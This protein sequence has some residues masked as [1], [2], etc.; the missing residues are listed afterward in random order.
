MTRDRRLPRPRRHGPLF[1]LGLAVLIVGT[2]GAGWAWAAWSTPTRLTAAA[3]AADFFPPQ[4]VRVPQIA[5]T[6]AD[7]EVLTVVPAQWTGL[8][9]GPT[10]SYTWTR[11]T[12]AAASS[13]SVVA[14]GQ[15]ATSVSVPTGAT[16]TWRYTVTETITNGTHTA[17][18]SS[19]PTPSQ[20]PLDIVGL[21]LIVLNLTIRLMQVTTTMPTVGGTAAVGSTLTA[22][23]GA[24]TTRNLVGALT[25]LLNLDAQQISYQWFRCGLVGN[26]A[27]PSASAA[28]A[29]E[30]IGGA[31]SQTYVPVALDRG[32]RLQVRVRSERSLLFLG[33]AGVIAA[34]VL[35]TFRGAVYAEPTAVVP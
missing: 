12:L 30:E 8:A 32:H 14:S 10:R 33:V 4:L 3:T 18:A 5:G 11:C 17:T 26:P 1:L 21:N 2:V 27:S 13:C 7:N 20:L 34:R 31:T 22:T 28:H 6:A 25:G 9:S 15:A 16:E 19:V 29:C 24:W 23:P 35:G